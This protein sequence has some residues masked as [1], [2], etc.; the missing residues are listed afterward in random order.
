MKQYDFLLFDVDNTLMDFNRAEH[1]ALRDCLIQFGF[2]GDEALIR[3]YSVINDRHWKMLE[4]GEI[5]REVL[6]WKRFEAF[7][8]ECDLKPM[9]AHAFSEAYVEQLSHKAYLLDGALEVCRALA[10]RYTLCAITNGNAK[11]QHGRFDPSPIYPYFHKTFISD[12]MG[13]DKPSQAYFDLVKA[14]LPSLDVRRTLVIGDSLTSDIAGGVAWGTDTCWVCPRED[15][16]GAA[17]DKGLQ[18][19]YVIAHLRELLDI[20]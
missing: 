11:V 9:D 4:R 13:V 19:T 16:R 10:E 17:A 20:L 12:E 7:S 3:A 6:M 2:P 8:D 14:A 1:D 18:P 15:K 5:E